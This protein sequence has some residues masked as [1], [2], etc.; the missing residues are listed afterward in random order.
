MLQVVGGRSVD[1]HG[2]IIFSLLLTT[3][4]MKSRKKFYGHSIDRVINL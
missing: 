2:P 3:H 1:L 4:Q